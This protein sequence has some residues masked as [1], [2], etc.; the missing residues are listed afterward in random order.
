MVGMG[1]PGEIN[2]RLGIKANPQ[3]MLQV[4]TL[5][6][7]AAR[8]LKE[9]PPE[10]QTPATAPAG[11]LGMPGMSPMHMTMEQMQ[12]F[13]MQQVRAAIPHPCT[14][15]K[16]TA[17]APALGWGFLHSLKSMP[18]FVLFSSQTNIKLD[19]PGRTA[20]H[21]DAVQG[22]KGTPLGLFAY[23]CTC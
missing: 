15:R 22:S 23:R 11:M 9:M 5:R 7:V 19:M 2:R 20:V 12:M 6:E 21:P 3:I 17:E 10:P 14:S 13:Q 4:K 8:V 18:P 1:V 16:L